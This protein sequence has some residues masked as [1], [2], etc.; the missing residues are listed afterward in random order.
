[1]LRVS[2]L[3]GFGGSVPDTT[4]PTIT[5]A[6]TDSVGG[7][8]TLAHAL[9]ANESVTWSIVGGADQAQFDIS[10]STL[11]WLANGT[12]DYAS[13]AD[14]DTNNTYIVTVRATDLSSNTTDQTITVTVTAPS[15]ILLESSDF[16]LLESGDKILME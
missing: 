11:R 2:H 6:N 13:P 12:Q 10:G 15:S 1:M 5:S 4:P 7:G 8:A 9:T 16:M 14:A 3:A